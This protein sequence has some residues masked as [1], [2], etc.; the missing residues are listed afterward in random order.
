MSLKYIFP[1]SDIAI[2]REARQLAEGHPMANDVSFL[3]GLTI[4]MP[5]LLTD[6]SRAE[7]IAY[8]EAYAQSEKDRTRLASVD[9]R[10]VGA[11][12]VYALRAERSRLSGNTAPSQDAGTVAVGAA[13]DQ[14]QHAE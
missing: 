4:A 5:F 2:T 13:G 3:R 7:F 9:P 10:D 12:A 11:A 1:Y 6:A 14:R 8:A